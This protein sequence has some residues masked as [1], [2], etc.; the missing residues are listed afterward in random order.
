M[1]KHSGMFRVDRIPKNDKVT[2]VGG[3]T[4]DNMAAGTNVVG[5]VDGMLQR[6]DS[7]TAANANHSGDAHG[8]FTSANY[9]GGS[10]GSSQTASASSGATRCLH[11]GNVPA[12]MTEIQ[13]M[14][15]FEKFGQLEG[16]KLVSQRNGS[17]RFAFVTFQTVEQAVSAR[18][19]LS[20]VHPWKSAISFAHKDFGGSGGGGHS[21]PTAAY[22]TPSHNSRHSNS[23]IQ[24]AYLQDTRHV[25]VPRYGNRMYP[26]TNYPQEFHNNSLYQL[27]SNPHH[28]MMVSH[29]GHV[30]YPY[31]N[32]PYSAASGPPL[33]WMPSQHSLPLPFEHGG[34]VPIPPSIDPLQQGQFPQQPPQQHPQTTYTNGSQSASAV[35][36]SIERDCPV[37]QRLC[38]DTYVPTQPWPADHVRDLPYCS[39][40]VAQMQQFGGSTTVS[41]LRGFLRNRIS[42]T[43]NIKS[44]PL[45]AMIVAYPQLFVLENNY[46]YLVGGGGSA[47]S[48]GS[49]S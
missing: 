49:T 22:P 40:V 46:V 27:Q 32:S 26:G 18:H 13:L 39:A 9:V 43:D 21:Q 28:Q 12:N 14:R 31:L 33:Y 45:K 10:E 35:A 8:G 30:P 19:A 11:V 44:V 24:S 42:A 7:R 1:E 6:P 41:K 20:K 2:L 3:G 37:L 25:G 38:D 5:S 34:T 17:R 29:G 47:S 23:N 48:D 4:A 15:E 36:G 16:L